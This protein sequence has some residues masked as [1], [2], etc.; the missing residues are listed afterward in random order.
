MIK[1]PTKFET[2]DDLPEWMRD[3]QEAHEAQRL[4]A[5]SVARQANILAQ[6]VVSQFLHFTNRDESMQFS[7][8]QMRDLI[9]MYSRL[10]EYT[11]AVNLIEKNLR[12]LH[13]AGSDEKP[14]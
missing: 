8:Y 5:W 11:Q 7:W 10:C 13:D 9:R 4:C 6:D 14:F 12:E 2:F 3:R 1:E